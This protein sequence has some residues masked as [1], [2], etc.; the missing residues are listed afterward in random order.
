MPPVRLPA[1]ATAGIGSLPHTQLELAMQQAL[2]LDIPTLPQLPRTD[3][4]EYML[5]QA[6]D[7]FPGLAFESDGRTTVDRKAWEA[8]AP[9][10]G[11]KLARALA[12]EGLEAFE[13]TARSSRAWKPFLW[14]VEHRK[15]P[16]AKAQL[17]GPLTASWATTFTDG[18]PISTVP[19]VGAQL[20]QQVVARALAMTKAL[21]QTGTQPLIFL[22][23]PGLYAYDKRRP[24]HVVELQELQIAATAL[25]RAG[26]LVGVHC[27]GNTDWSALLRLPFDVV[28]GDVRLSLAAMLSTGTVLD[29]FLAR[30]GF[31]A[32]GM[33]PTN[34]ATRIAPEELVDDALALLGDRRKAVLARALVTPACGLALRTVIESEQVYDDVREVQHLLQT[35]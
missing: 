33:V 29:E 24:S 8:G 21:V 28:S 13:P 1:L 6:L 22:D 31:L 10:Y 9:A 34:L 26:A 32:L 30:G 12:G 18:S 14:E 27:C 4:G 25:K 2:R 23:E 11:Q 15:A 7:A 17:T 20:V 35:A 3:A 16:F 5:P 19:E